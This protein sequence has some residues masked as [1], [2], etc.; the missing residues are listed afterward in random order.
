VI[1]V[2]AAQAMLLSLAPPVRAETVALGAALGR[3]MLEPAVARIDQPPFPASAMDGYA[4]AGEA[5]PGARFAVVGEAAA[6]R[7]FPGRLGPG[8]A[9]RIFTG[10][11]VPEGA[12]RVVIQEDVTHAGEAIT[13]GD[14]P[15]AGPHVRARGQDFRAG[16][17]VSPRW[18]R[19]VD[20]ALIGAMGHGAVSVARAPEV[21]VISTGDELV[22]PGE[23]PGPGQIVATNALVVAA[24][25]R[26]AGAVARVLPIARDRAG[27]LAA[28]L[29]LAEGADLVVTSGGASV[30]DHDLVA[31]VAAEAGFA[32]AFHR[33]ALRPGKPLMAGRRGGTV[34]LGL[35]GNPVSAVVCAMLFM[36]P[37]LRA[38]QG[39]PAPLPRP[40]RAVLAEPV[41]PTGPRTHYMRARL[42]PAEGLPA[43]RPLPRQ[44]SALLTVLAGADALLVRPLGEGPQP[45]GATVDYLPL[46]MQA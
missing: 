39:D 12:T 44:D 4:V 32:P 45:S 38:M 5:P 15:D 18:L 3:R 20:L 19:P 13:V 1:T 9:V 22:P 29:A 34:L 30:G 25:A 41:G 7:G 43:I 46:L 24:M 17:A 40:L 6:G 8:E 28:V 33:I 2:E 16:D 23:T 26:Q 36:L 14:R 37:L 10:A 42:E 21:A 35:P 27:H 11:P 31:R